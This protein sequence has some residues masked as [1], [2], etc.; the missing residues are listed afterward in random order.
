[1]LDYIGNYN[2]NWS[3]YNNCTDYAMDTLEAADIDTNNYDYITSGVADPD[4]LRDAILANG[5]RL[6]E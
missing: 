6:I 1:M 2:R 3:L 5:G 4:K